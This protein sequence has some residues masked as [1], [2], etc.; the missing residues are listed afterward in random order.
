MAKIEARGSSLEE[1]SKAMGADLTKKSTPEDD[2]HFEAQLAA[3]SGEKSNVAVERNKRMK[4]K[5][6]GA[7]ELDLTKE[8]EALAHRKEEAA[9][10][11]P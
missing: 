1:A 3:M 11:E 9:K 10:K 2:A 5:F 4:D 8:R 7:G 6:G